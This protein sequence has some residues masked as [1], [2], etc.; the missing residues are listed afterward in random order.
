M[1]SSKSY[2]TQ[3]LFQVEIAGK[4]VTKEICRFISS[5]EYADKL[6]EQS[7]ECMI[8]LD[9][10]QGLWQS[11]W[12]PTQGDTLNLKIGYPGNLLDCGSFEIDECELNGQ[13]DVFTIRGIASAIT[14]DLRTKNSR[15]YENQSLRKIAQV[16]A[17][18][19]G[20]NLM[21]DTSR[22]SEIEVER[23]TQNYES[24]LSF[25]SNLCKRFGIVFSI[26]GKDLIFLNSEDIE[27]SEPV[28]SFQR[29][30]IN[31]YNF[32]DKTAETYESAS[33][34]KRDIRKNKVQ[35]WNVKTSGDPTKK[36]TLVV[37]GRVENAGQAE[38]LAVGNLRDKNKEKLTG[39]FQ[40]DGNILLVAGANV[41]LHGF[42]AFSGKW[43]IRESRHV[44]S[45]DDVGKNSG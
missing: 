28:L 26:R 32:K 20:L 38:A 19:H 7:D 10:I 24:D 6:E 3:P 15:A 23:K 18:K 42:G 22:L 2:I 41:E 45:V 27:N 39:S 12:Y 13:P 14:T 43:M 16:I 1:K 21:G 33:V 29:W 17:D 11:D 34:S 35:K 8:V 36:D 40:A 30:Q 44:I 9:D 37:G 25:L 5:I 31:S 4:N